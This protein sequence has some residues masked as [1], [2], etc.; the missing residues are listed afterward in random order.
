MCRFPVYCVLKCAIQS[1]GYLSR[2][3]KAAFA[4]V[5]IVNL[6]CGGYHLIFP[7]GTK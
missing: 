2:K 4:F 5:S 6:M 7:K 1:S 3:G